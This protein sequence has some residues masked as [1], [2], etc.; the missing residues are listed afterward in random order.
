MKEILCIT[1]YP[2][3]E[4]GIATFSDD[5]IRAIEAKF[6]SSF[7]IKV[8]AL[9]SRSEQHVYGNQVKYVLDT[10]EADDFQH[11]AQKINEDAEIE[12]VLIQHEFGLF[13]EHDKEFLA[14][15]RLIKIPVVIVFHTVLPHPLRMQKEYLGQLAEACSAVIVMTQTSAE[16]L[17][18]EYDIDRKKINIIPHGTHL[19]SHKDRKILKEKYKVT[20]RRILST[21]GLLSPGKSIETTLEALPAI[22]KENPAVLFLIIGKTHPAILK[23][24]GESYREM[25]KAKVLALGLT[26]YVRFVNLYLDLPVLLEYLQLTDV[27]LFTSADPNQAVSGTFVYALSCGCPIIATPIPHALELLKDKSGQIFDFKDSSQLATAANKLLGSEKLRSRMRIAGLQKTAATAWENTAIAYAHLFNR[28]L[29]NEEALVYSLP[30]VNVDHIKR[31]SR[32]FA[33]I[34]F[35]KGN[36]PDVRTGYTLDDNAR[37]LIALCRMY[38]ETKDASCEKYIKK[39]L[40]FISHCQ[41]PD[42]SFLNYVDKDL[43][44]TSQND[45]VLLDDSNARAI[46]ALGYFISHRGKFPDVWTEKA[47]E[48][49]EQTFDLI[50]KMKSPRSIAFIIKGLYYFHQTFPAKEIEELILLSA[51]RL[52]SYYRQNREDDWRWFEAYLTYDNSILPESLL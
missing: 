21:F 19:V 26:D 48:I 23:T 47:V 2:P 44:F 8:C 41:H 49:F 33:M 1:T 37:A 16:I 40:D 30:P 50:S 25:L 3:R 31:M 6:G 15:T 43:L 36:R 20:G 14:F 17:Q 7:V 4:C 24:V 22:V 29:E 46:Y 13:A 28:E 51:N 11:T 45:E 5:L 27:Y 38:V 34:Q 12:L 9:A 18:K 10:S 32:S 35:S 39:Y 52:V 42:G